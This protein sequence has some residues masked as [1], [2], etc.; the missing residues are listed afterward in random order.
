MP[1]IVGR[2]STAYPPGI[3]GVYWNEVV[4]SLRTS[5]CV[6]YT[7]STYVRTYGKEEV[8][9]NYSGYGFDLLTLKVEREQ[10]TNV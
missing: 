5:K 9:K 1:V 6:C 10:P 2:V 8:A 3:Q 7:C 4:S